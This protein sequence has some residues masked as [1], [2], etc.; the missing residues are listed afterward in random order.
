MNER[1]TNWDEDNKLLDE[2]NSR[3]YLLLIAY[4]LNNKLVAQLRKSQVL[5]RPA[6]NSR[7]ELCQNV[8]HLRQVVHQVLH[9]VRPDCCHPYTLTAL[10]H[11]KHL[12]SQVPCMEMVAK[13]GK[14]KSDNIQV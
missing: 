5:L 7:H 9:Q 3:V 2:L 8:I 11:P 13:S 1:K 14:L 12:R 6:S 10:W 4:K